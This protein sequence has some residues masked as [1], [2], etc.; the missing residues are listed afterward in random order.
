MFASEPQRRLPASLE[1]ETRSGTFL[2]LGAYLF[3]VKEDPK[4][5]MPSSKLGIAL[6]KQRPRI[7]KKQAGIIYG[8]MASSLFIDRVNN[9]HEKN[10]AAKRETDDFEMVVEP[11]IAQ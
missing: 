5:S 8:S 11:P 10:E 7:P 6:A 3:T 1:L 2:A 9:S 4:A